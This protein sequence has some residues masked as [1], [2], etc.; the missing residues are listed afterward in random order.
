M[1]NWHKLYMSR[2]GTYTLVFRTNTDDTFPVS[3]SLKAMSKVIQDGAVLGGVVIVGLYI[4][5]IFELVNRTLSA[6]LAA[7]AAIGVLAFFNEVSPSRQ[8]DIMIN[9]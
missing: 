4:L 8:V 2:N 5:I 7:T 6:I 3:F 1:K 9:M